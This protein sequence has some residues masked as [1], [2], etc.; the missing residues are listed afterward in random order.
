MILPSNSSEGRSGG[1]Y[2]G[3]YTPAL[4]FVSSLPSGTSSPTQNDFADNKIGFYS[5]YSILGLLRFSPKA[6]ICWGDKPQ[7]GF[8]VISLG[9]GWR[10]YQGTKPIWERVISLVR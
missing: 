7:A 3:V 9:E 10:S 4:I 1:A 2:P 8:G 5:Y 6:L